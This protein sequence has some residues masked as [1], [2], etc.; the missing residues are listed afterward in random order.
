MRC[1]GQ[2][3]NC[4]F[5]NEGLPSK[6]WARKTKDR[7]DLDNDKP[8]LRFCP[9]PRILRSFAVL[10][11]SSLATLAQRLRQAQDDKWALGTRCFHKLS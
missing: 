7:A 2:E 6:G 9:M 11:R 10:R 5:G 3:R 4:D 8:L 1:L